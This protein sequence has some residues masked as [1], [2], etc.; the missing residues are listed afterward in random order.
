MKYSD[1]VRNIFFFRNIFLVIEESCHN[2][3]EFFIFSDI[4]S[5]ISSLHRSSPTIFYGSIYIEHIWCKDSESDSIK[6]SKLLY[7]C[8]KIINVYIF[9]NRLSFSIENSA[10]KVISITSHTYLTLHELTH[11]SEG[12]MCHEIRLTEADT[13]STFCHATNIDLSF[14]IIE[15]RYSFCLSCI[16]LCS[17]SFDSIY[18]ILFCD[19]FCYIGLTVDVSE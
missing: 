11:A 10:M 17:I 6:S 9:N 4:E 7:C 13:S 16:H 19:I 5:P 14:L 18:E 1:K 12:I 8:I 3:E 2:L 15:F